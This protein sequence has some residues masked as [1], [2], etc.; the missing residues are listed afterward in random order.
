MPEHQFSI[1]IDT[2]QLNE[3]EISHQYD[4]WYAD[5]I[6]EQEYQELK[7]KPKVGQQMHFNFGN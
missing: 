7:R 3:E 2:S 6:L 1:F 4:L 5:T